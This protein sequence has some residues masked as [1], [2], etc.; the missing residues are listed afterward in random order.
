MRRLV[1]IALS[2]VLFQNA[3]HGLTEQDIR[4][5]ELH[6]L[7]D[8]IKAVRE[9]D[10]SAITYYVEA[11]LIAPEHYKVLIEEAD[12]I[13]ARK[14]SMARWP[15]AWI[16]M[17]VGG[18]LGFVP[19]YGAIN[20]YHIYMNPEM[21]DKA[22]KVKL[23]KWLKNAEGAHSEAKEAYSE[24]MNEYKAANDE[25]LE[26]FKKYQE[27]EKRRHN[28]W[29]PAADP[30]ITWEEQYRLDRKR[31]SKDLELTGQRNIVSEKAKAVK[32][33]K[34]V[35]NDSDKLRDELATM[36]LGTTDFL[37]SAVAV[38]LCWYVAYNAWQAPY[39]A[40]NGA[41]GM[42]TMLRYVQKKACALE[43]TRVN[44]QSAKVPRNVGIMS[45]LKLHIN[46]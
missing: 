24:A 12:I 37:L 2:A 16:K 1:Y 17:V 15:W 13:V 40:Y 3:A 31:Y 4:A 19:F 14:S 30:S 5:A 34:K 22:N 11:D 36:R 32:R 26:Y 28:P 29:L 44:A 35:L 7:G 41:K 25:Y 39:K 10:F 6:T 23:E 33:Q 18:A 8:A 9:G 21:Q 38:A 27:N 42:A 45:R 20:N 46:E 43:A